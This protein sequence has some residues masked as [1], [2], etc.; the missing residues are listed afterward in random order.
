MTSWAGYAKGEPEEGSGIN[1][2][3][4]AWTVPQSLTKS[5]PSGESTWVG[6]GGSTVFEGSSTWGLI[7]AGSAMQ[8]NYGYRYFWEYIGSSGC[9][10]TTAFCGQYSSVNYIRP[11]DAMWAEVTW[12]STT[13]AC[14]SLDDITR[15]EAISGCHQV[16][17]PYDHTSAEWINEW[18]PDIN[19]G[20][21]DSP[22]T[23]VWSSQ[24]LNDGFNGSGAWHSPFSGNYDAMIMN[25][26]SPDGPFTC[27]AGN[28]VISYPVNASTDSNGGFSETL[29]CSIY[30]VDSP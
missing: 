11:G 10:D 16:N 8:T 2:V 14:F 13:K 21:Y 24:Q 30:G 15:G 22:G 27:G 26:Y 9:T 3:V 5:A 12:A 25:E 4:G 23:V 1:G 17:I 7:Q 18:P 19:P 6:L 28:G 20:Y 29:T